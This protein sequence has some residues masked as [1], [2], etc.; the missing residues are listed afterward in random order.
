MLWG[1]AYMSAQE[2]SVA[3]AKVPIVAMEY[4]KKLTIE[5]LAVKC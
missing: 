1:R 4:I 3:R 5:E 2:G